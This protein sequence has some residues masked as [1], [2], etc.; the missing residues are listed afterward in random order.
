MLAMEARDWHLSASL[1]LS[2]PCS[3]NCPSC[4]STIVMAW[5][6][7]FASPPLLTHQDVE[8]HVYQSL[9]VV[10][11]FRLPREKVCKRNA[12]PRSVASA[13]PP[14]GLSSAFGCFAY[15]SA[16]RRRTLFSVQSSSDHSHLDN[17]SKTKSA[18]SSTST[19]IPHRAR[20]VLQAIDR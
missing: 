14:L 4:N 17:A 10:S 5:T 12:R 13:T 6:R 8:F 11:Y 19:Q 9:A 2:D 7:R 1:R 16:T 20:A 15:S 18:A 3:D